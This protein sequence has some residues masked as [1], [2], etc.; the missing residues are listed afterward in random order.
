LGLSE[1]A[2]VSAASF[3]SGQPQARA[4]ADARDGNRGAGPAHRTSKAAP[5]HKI[6]PCLLRGVSITE[7]NHVWASD[8]TYI[9]MAL[10]F[11]YLVAIID[12]A[13]R[14]VLAWG[15]RTRW[16]RVLHRRARR[17]TGTDPFS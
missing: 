1:A 16:I 3:I 5:G 12:W 17:S 8:I 9:P 13:T 10:G 4:K 11:L 2:S 6:Y 14:A 15:C 7:P